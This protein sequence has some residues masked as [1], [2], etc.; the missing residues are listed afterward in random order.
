MLFY[1]WERE[2]KREREAE[3]EGDTESEAAPGSQLSAQRPTWALNPLTT[4][5]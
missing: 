3:R 4:R 2:R 5:S 1:F